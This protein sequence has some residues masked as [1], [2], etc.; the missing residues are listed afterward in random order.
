M[1]TYPVLIDLGWWAIDRDGL[2]ATFATGG[3]GPVPSYFL[4]LSDGSQTVL[5]D[6]F[7]A[8]PVIN[9]RNTA[10]VC[11]T[12]EAW[13][14]P[15]ERGLHCYDWEDVHRPASRHSNVYEL[16]GRPPRHLTIDQVPADLRQMLEPLR[17]RTISFAGEP[18]VDVTQ[19]LP[20]TR[21]GS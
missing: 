14:H 19:H 9:D 11:S 13:V 21:P 18:T 4:T 16:Q 17:M 1:S 20:C 3:V 10:T 2:I 12:N 7:D 6:F 5:F 8:L 15:V